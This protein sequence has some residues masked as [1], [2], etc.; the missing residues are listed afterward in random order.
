MSRTKEACAQW[1]GK[2][3]AI[4]SKHTKEKSDLEQ[5]LLERNKT[6]SALQCQLNESIS[7]KVIYCICCTWTLLHSSLSTAT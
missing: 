6:I 3:D 5:K 4:T 2:M 7:T 1:T